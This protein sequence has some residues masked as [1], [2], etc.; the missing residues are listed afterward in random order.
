M[1]FL[2][3]PMWAMEHIKVKPLNKLIV[4]FL[5]LNI[6]DAV[7]THI[8]LS[9]G[10]GYEANPVLGGLIG[11]S[12]WAFWGWKVGGAVTC[13]ALLL[14]AARKYPASAH[15][16]LKVLVVA[17]MVVCVWNMVGLV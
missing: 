11:Q 15:R 10:D 1:P 7:L 4:G 5:S 14:L 3:L 2:G 13:V 16:I 12:W 6:L 17:M 8:V 9:R